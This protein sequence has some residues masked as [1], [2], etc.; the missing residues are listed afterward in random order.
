MTSDQARVFSL[1]WGY[2]AKLDCPEPLRADVV[3]AVCEA[4][5]DLRDYDRMKHAVRALGWIKS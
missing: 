2:W 3:K 5:A 4:P 1:V